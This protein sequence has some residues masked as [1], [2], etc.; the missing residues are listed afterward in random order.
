M[1]HTTMTNR[2]LPAVY[3][4]TMFLSLLNS[5]NAQEAIPRPTAGEVKVRKAL[6][7]KTEFDFVERSLAEVAQAIGERHHIEVQLDRAIGD[8]IVVRHTDDVRQRVA[9]LLEDLAPRQVVHQPP[10][11]RPP[12]LAV[13]GWG[14]NWPQSA[15][16][17]FRT[18]GLETIGTEEIDEAIVRALAAPAEF[19]V[20]ETPLGDVLTQLGERYGVPIQIDH[21]ALE[22]ESIG[23]DTPITRRIRGVPLNSLLHSLLDESDLTFLIFHGEVVLITAK[24]EC[25]SIS[26]VKVYPV[27]DLVCRAAGESDDGTG[28]DYQALI[29]GLTTCV[30]PTTWDDVGGPGEIVVFAPAGA[31]VI[32]QTM[33]VH[34][35][36]AQYLNTLREVAA[37]RV[38]SGG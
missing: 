32:S 2:R 23:L 14:T 1:G 38:M 24:V 16:P 25:E 18:R 15:E 28:L 6:D 20:S 5:G 13:R 31:I 11:A 37:E 36:I 34:D 17:P 35:E 12:P 10:P 3:W 29:D 27:F 33:S 7:E 26:Y 4:T 8:S 9:M 22:E 30:A 21:R 19:D